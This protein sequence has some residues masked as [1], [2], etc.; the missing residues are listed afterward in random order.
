M[1]VK[2]VDNTHQVLDARL[3]AVFELVG[4]MEGCLGRGRLLDCSGRE[5]RLGPLG[6]M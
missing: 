1:K 2:K 6:N 5:R 4:G 3:F